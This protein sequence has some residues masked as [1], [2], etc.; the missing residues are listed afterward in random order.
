MK[1]IALFFFLII[2]VLVDFSSSQTCRSVKFW[3]RA[4]GVSNCSRTEY[5]KGFYRVATYGH[6]DLIHFL[7]KASCCTAPPP[8]ENSGQSCTSIDLWDELNHDNT[9]AKCPPGMFIQG[10]KRTGFLYSWLSH[11]E[12]LICC[13]PKDVTPSYEDCHEKYVSFHDQGWSMCDLDYYLAGFHRGNCRS[14]YCLDQFKCCKFMPRDINECEKRDTCGGEANCENTFGSYKCNCGKGYEYSAKRRDCFDIDE[15]REPS[16]CGPN[17]NCTNQ[18]STYVCS[19][20]QGYESKNKRKLNCTDIDEC[21]T[22]THK[23]DPNSYCSNNI[24]SYGCTC[25]EGFKMSEKKICKDI[26]ECTESHICGPHANCTNQPST[27]VCSCAKGYE[28]KDK[29]KFKCTDIDE[30]MSQTHKCDPNSYCSNTIGSYGCKCKE[31]FKMSEKKICKDIDEC[32]TPNI[33]GPREKCTNKPATYVC[34]CAKGYE[35]KD[36]HKLNCTDIDECREPNICGPHTMCSNHPGTFVCFCAEGYESK[37]KNKLNCI[38][39]D[40][41]ITQRSNC[42]RNS[43]CSNTIGSFGCTCKEGFK[44]SD[45]GSCEE[46]CYGECPE[47]AECR[48]GRCQCF[49]GFALGPYNECYEESFFFIEDSSGICLHHPIVP[50]AFVPLTW[51]TLP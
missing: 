13:S 23:C 14:L 4:E 18:P 42:Q 41:C 7:K 46:D 32:R 43:Y 51:L 39:I 50:L 36:K 1:S 37:D 9:W 6:L 35:S 3:Q 47:N 44:M 48:D 11:I 16:I 19:C 25:K 27:Y 2:L 38:D 21:M 40:E 34:S 45:E 10:V 20:M 31:G 8:D 28:S 22:Q 26:D 30:C 15:C 24:G 49:A 5:L 17:A 33:C 12:E 29:N